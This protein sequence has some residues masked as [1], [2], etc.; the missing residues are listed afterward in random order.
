M[1]LL[2]QQ[3][4]FFLQGSL[5]KMTCEAASDDFLND[6]PVYYIENE[7]SESVPNEAIVDCFQNMTSRRVQ[8]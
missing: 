8:L 5:L 3:N 4:E 6:C 1:L 2:Q 7:V